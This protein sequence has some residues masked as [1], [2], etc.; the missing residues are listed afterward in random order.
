MKFDPFKWHEV[1]PNG[2]TSV[3]K[4]RVQLRCSAS[5]PLYAEAEGVETL[6]GV[7]TDFDFETSVPVTI[8]VDA[9]P[10]VRVFYYAML[11][12][13]HESEGEVIYTNADAM[14]LESGNLAEVRREL[15][16]FELQ[17]RAAIKEIRQE[18]AILR[19]MREEPVVVNDPAP[20]N[21]PADP[22]APAPDPVKAK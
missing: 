17:K 14:P 5:S 19:A 15:R 7:G 9:G 12:D 21:P 18:T 13:S 4:G 10:T 16:N 6:V 2:K 20:A 22:P 1:K 3:K 11:S 8:R